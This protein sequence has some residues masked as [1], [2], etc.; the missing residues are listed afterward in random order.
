[1]I[2]AKD[3]RIT[4]IIDN[5]TTSS[6]IL[7]EWGFSVLLEAGTKTFLFDTGASEAAVS[8]ADRLHLN[9]NKIDAIVLSHGHF[10]HTGGLLPVLQRIDRT[11]IRIIA[12]PDVMDRKYIDDENDEK[13]RYIGVPYRQD[14]LEQVG[15]H[16]EFQKKPVWLTK[17]I[18][19]SGEEPMM[20]DFESVSENLYFKDKDRF[21]PDPLLD[22]QSIYIRTDLGLIIILG[23]AHRGMI[24]IL[25]HARELMNTDKIHMVIGG[26]HLNPASQKQIERTIQS[27]KEIN[28]PWIGVSHCTGLEVGARL[29]NEFKGKFFFNSAGTIITFPFR[30]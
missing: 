10:D 8:N 9:L 23:C 27:L 28:I 11:D 6:E 15:G 16:F 12:H 21:F 30:L 19:A 1:M 7:G 14:L 29:A 13:Y 2:K 17:D 25:H 22:E 26:T 24:N 3:L 5:Y 20:T 18:V 4:T